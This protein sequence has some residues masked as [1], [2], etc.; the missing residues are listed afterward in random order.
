MKKYVQINVKPQT[1]KHPHRLPSTYKRETSPWRESSTIPLP[2]PPHVPNSVFFCCLQLNDLGAERREG[3]ERHLYAAPIVI[4]NSLK[5]SFIS[6][7]T[8]SSAM[9]A[10]HLKFKEREELF[11]HIYICICIYV[12]IHIY[13]KR[14]P[15][16]E[17][18]IVGKTMKNICGII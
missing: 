12:H 8:P 16:R 6:L 15:K 5:V 9:F 4:C 17:E 13:D 2:P 11:L 10:R 14:I 18:L 1:K 7:P 3:T